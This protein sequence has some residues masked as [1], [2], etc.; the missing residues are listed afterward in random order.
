MKKLCVITSNKD[1]NLFSLGNL[2]D[3]GEFLQTEDNAVSIEINANIAIE[4][5]KA[6]GYFIDDQR[7]N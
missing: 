1:F 6:Q 7:I 2:L 3:D 5:Y 4:S